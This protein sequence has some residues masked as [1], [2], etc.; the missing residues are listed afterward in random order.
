MSATLDVN[1]IDDTNAI[2]VGLEGDTSGVTLDF[3]ENGA[4]HKVLQIDLGS[5]RSLSSHDLLFLTKDID[6]SGS[7]ITNEHL[8]VQQTENVTRATS[9]PSCT[10]NEQVEDNGS[11]SSVESC[12]YSNVT[13]MDSVLSWVEVPLETFT[14]ATEDI[15]GV[16]SVTGRYFRYAFDVPFTLR[17]DG[18]YGSTGK[19]YMETGGDTF[20]NL[21]H[22]SWWNTNFSYRKPIQIN[23]SGSVSLRQWYTVEVSGLDTSS[24]TVFNQSNTNNFAVVCNGSEVDKIIGNM[25]D[26]QSTNTTAL[27]P[28][29][30]GYSQVNTTFLFR[31]P[32]AVPAATINSTLCYV[33]YGDLGFTSSMNNKSNIALF[34]DDFARADSSTVGKNWIEDATGNTFGISSNGLQASAANPMMYSP[35]DVGSCSDCELTETMY[36]YKR[37]SALAG[38]GLCVGV[39]SYNGQAGSGSCQVASG[40]GAFSKFSDE[41]SFF[42]FFESDA[43]NNLFKQETRVIPSDASQLARAISVGTTT[44]GDYVG[45]VENSYVTWDVLNN[46]VTD[47]DA[48]RSYVHVGANRNLNRLEYVFVKRWMRTPPT[49]TLGLEE[50]GGAN[51]DEAT[52]RVAM[53]AAIQAALPL[54][55]VYTDQQIYSRYANGSQMLGTFDM[56]AQY[57]N[58]VWGFNYVNGTETFTHMNPIMPSLFLWENSSIS[59]TSVQTQVQTYIEATLILSS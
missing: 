29:S 18:T 28:S 25:T 23:N 59:S 53:F 31:M 38:S 54:A 21:Q 20:V 46:T 30:T 12:T 14:G 56:I 3:V 10:E 19:V 35:L 24:S 34:Y 6:F 57:R 4:T 37:N 7:Q 2:D 43:P 5:T 36:W 9:V 51:S 13:E 1:V 58:Q 8:Y 22:S 33:Y 48:T 26:L 42:G 40:N 39:D 11:I 49:I 16:N 17:S 15:T 45:Y 44:F 32:S 41:S 55:S 27:Y 50:T 52:A 47:A